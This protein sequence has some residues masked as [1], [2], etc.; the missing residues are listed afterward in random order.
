MASFPIL[1][2]IMKTTLEID[3]VKLKNLMHLRKIKTRREAVDYA[4]SEATHKAEMEAFFETVMD[5]SEYVNVIA[6][7]YDLEA[8]RNREMPK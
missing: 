3:E 5:H 1:K 2:P 4:L 7:D 6:E 8:L